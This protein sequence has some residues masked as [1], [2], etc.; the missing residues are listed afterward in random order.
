MV[1]ARLLGELQVEVNGQ[2]CTRFRTRKV[3]QLLAYLL[4]YPQRHPRERLL[5]LFWG[6]L[7]AAAARNNL[8]VALTMLRRLLEPLSVPAGTILQTDRRFVG[9]NP[10][11]I[12]T[13]V[14]AFEDALQQAANA[15][16]PA[17]QR[18]LLKRA[19][20]LYTGDFLIG[21]DE[22][23][24]QAERERL[25]QL[26]HDAL[27]Q[28]QPAE[29]R[30][31]LS[32]RDPT[33]FI[34]SNPPCGLGVV[35]GLENETPLE[36]LRSWARQVIG[37][38][39][40]FVL[41]A[42]TTGI[43][44][45]FSSLEALLKALDP[46]HAQLKAARF[47]MDIGELRYSLGRYGGKPLQVVEQ[48]LQAGYPHQILCTERAALLLPQA[49]GVTRFTLRHLGCYRLSE[50][51]SNEQVYQFDFAGRE[52]LFAPLRARSPL[53]PALPRVPT[54]FLGRDMELAQLQALL[55]ASEGQLIT[56]VGA[57]GVGKSRFILE[58]AWRMEPFFGEARWWIT[59]HGDEL[60][61]PAEY[62]AGSRRSSGE[63]IS[64]GESIAEALARRLGWEWRGV[65]PLVHALSG[66]LG[67]RP[68]L[69][70]IDGANA[71]SEG[72]KAEL[73]QLLRGITG[74]RVMVASQQPIGITEEQLFSLEPLPVPP[75]GVEEVEALQRYAAVRLFVERARQI[76]PDFRLTERNAA[77]VAALCRLLEGL[78][79]A[80]ELV[81][82]RVGSCSLAE[83][84][85]RLQSTHPAPLKWLSKRPS[86]A[87][88]HTLQASL[89]ATYA[90]LSA[91]AR[92]LLMWL[93][94]FRGGFTQAAAQ[95][96]ASTLLND[97]LLTAANKEK[98][99]SEA[100][101][102]LMRVSL[103]TRYSPLATHPDRERYRL[104]EPVR[105]FAEEQ[106]AS[107]GQMQQAREAHLNYM[108]MLAEQLQD[109][110]ESWEML[111]QERANLEA[112][113]AWGLEHA[114]GQALRLANAL[115]LFWERRGSG[116]T[117]YPLLCQLPDRLADIEQQLQAARI[118]TNLAVRRGDMAQAE[119][120]LQQYLPLAERR[121]E[122]R[123]SA[124]L[125]VMAGYYYWMQGECECS[126]A[127]LQRAIRRFQTLDAPLER[128]EALNHLAIALWIRE[129]LSAAACALEEALELTVPDTAPLLR[130]K[131]MS[132]L[133]NV[134]Y[135]MGQKE[136]AEALLIATLQLAQQ[137]GDQRTIATLLNNWSVWL[138]ERGEYARARELCLQANTLWQALHEGIGE[139]AAL[140]NLADIALHEGDHET[141]STLFHRS[142]ECILRN[143]L[144]WYLPRVLQNLAELAER[145]GALEEAIRW[146]SARLFVSLHEGQPQ[147]VAPT[148][149]ALAQLALQNNDPHN[150]A[151]WLIWL[152]R[153]AP[154][155]P[156]AW[157]DAIQAH[158]PPENLEQIRQE[159]Q[160]VSQE[161][162]LEPLRRLTIALLAP[163][164]EV[165]FDG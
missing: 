107:E 17:E 23:W 56:V 40:G 54:S 125:W 64:A 88:G 150:A 87:I 47:A 31:N 90:L 1:K 115:A 82:A 105:L 103:I 95:A 63:D 5:K 65:E 138:R 74:L 70:A 25:R 93:S 151:R 39:G 108:V 68:A 144:F 157:R 85:K 24:I 60:S 137:L 73:T 162:L 4:R 3:A 165:P 143:R 21:F 122:S 37:A 48:L 9:L 51:G 77:E 156:T 67:G 145:Q 152:E 127:Y 78:P 121:S 134:L 36:R 155:A 148:L 62:Q 104:L 18:Q 12:E 130:M 133:A 8:R 10:E 139:A 153:F 116:Q 147:Q 28:L 92:A 99:L 146:Q 69:L 15:S 123:V 27:Q 119:A 53:Q 33:T 61:L 113:L 117:I 140:N 94:V 164:G 58:C 142:L 13:D 114:P 45:F 159:V 43:R 19:C 101:S 6:D 84:R 14:A 135:Q 79:L 7:P 66:A 89:K 81:A 71:W 132:N 41:E 110:L 128:A 59:L 80:I 91:E 131:I 29:A 106:L 100:L 49:R 120:L 163:W 30:A 160:R 83:I 102:E 124:Q 11:L 76:A 22:P 158:L 154:E 129:E 26:Y 55:Q 38:S 16:N 57:P 112:A 96:I 50:Q 97:P 118:V 136:Q 161:Q 44:S 72:Q 111:E 32:S 20:S 75:E 34:A 149:Q 126:I 98:S 52:Q 109:K 141:A 2:P 86:G 46:L 42:T 35:L